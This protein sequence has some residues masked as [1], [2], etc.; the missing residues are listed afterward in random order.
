MQKLAYAWVGMT[1]MFNYMLDNLPPVLRSKLCS[2][3]LLCVCKYSFIK[4]YGVDVILQP[5]IED[6]KKLEK[7]NSIYII[8]IVVLRFLVSGCQLLHIW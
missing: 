8:H 3:Q 7:V 5:I 1:R 4:K 2:I 6:V